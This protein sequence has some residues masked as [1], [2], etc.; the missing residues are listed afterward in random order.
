[1]GDGDLAGVDRREKLE[2]EAQGKGRWSSAPFSGPD[3]AE[4]DLFMS[5]AMTR[6]VCTTITF[7]G[8]GGHSATY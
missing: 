8:H 1:M 2:G 3:S 4:H 7:H 6:L 5:M